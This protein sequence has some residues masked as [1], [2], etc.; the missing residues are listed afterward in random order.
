MVPFA[1]CAPALSVLG[2]GALGVAGYIG[3]SLLMRHAALMFPALV[4]VA[5]VIGLLDV[6]HATRAIP[7]VGEAAPIS[8]IRNIIEELEARDQGPFLVG[9]G[10]SNRGYGGR[11]G[12]YINKAVRFEFSER[13][14]AVAEDVTPLVPEQQSRHKLLDLE[15]RIRYKVFSTDA[16]YTPPTGWSEL[17]RNADAVVLVNHGALGDAW[18][19]DGGVVTPLELESWAPGKFVVRADASKGVALVVPA[20]A[21]DG[22][23]VSVDGGPSSPAIDFDGYATATTQEGDHIYEFTYRQPFLP[24]VLGLAALPWAAAAGMAIWA[25][26]YYLRVWRTRGHSLD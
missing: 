11:G 1:V 21:F 22:W 15:R 7:R 24:L 26:F 6:L 9:L 23:R 3:R 19:V 25:V 14:I 4:A 16:S 5:A 12:M 8:S 10:T 13:G 20:N 2:V 18:L 17:T